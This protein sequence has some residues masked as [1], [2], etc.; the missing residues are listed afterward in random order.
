MTN[1]TLKPIYDAPFICPKCSGE[2]FGRDTANE[3]GEVVVLRTV[4]CHDQFGIGCKW[5]GEWPRIK[6]ESN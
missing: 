4:R 5:H 1:E 3:N 2:Y 6:Q